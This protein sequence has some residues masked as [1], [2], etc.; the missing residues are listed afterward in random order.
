MLADQLALSPPMDRP[1]VA[2]TRPTATGHLRRRARQGV[3]LDHPYLFGATS[4]LTAPR[5]GNGV[6]D[7]A[8]ADRDVHGSNIVSGG[9][10]GGGNVSDTE[11]TDSLRGIIAAGRA[12]DRRSAG[13]EARIRVGKVWTPIAPA[14]PRSS[15][16]HPLAI[17]AGARILTSHSTS[18][19][20]QR[21]R[22]P[23]R[24]R[25]PGAT[26]AP[27]REQRPDLYLSPSYPASSSDPAVIASP[28]PPRAQPD[29]L[30]K[31]R[32]RRLTRRSGGGDPSTA[33]A[34]RSSTAPERRWPALCRC[35]LALL[36]AARPYIPQSDRRGA[37]RQARVERTRGPA[38]L[39]RAPRRSRC[40]PPAGHRW[41]RPR[42]PAPRWPAPRRAAR[43][44][45]RPSAGRVAAVATLRGGQPPSTVAVWL[46][47]STASACEAGGDRAAS[48]PS[49]SGAKDPPLDGRATTPPASESRR[50]AQLPAPR[51]ADG[52]ARDVSQIAIARLRTPRSCHGRRQWSRACESDNGSMSGW[53]SRGR[54][55]A[56]VHEGYYE[57]SSRRRQPG[58]TRSPGRRLS[59]LG[60]D[61]LAA[62]VGRRDTI[63]VPQV[64]TS[65]AR[66]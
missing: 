2:W 22:L 32:A 57:S 12:R 31:P 16:A 41:R 59:L 45:L 40:T 4:V 38:R 37:L 9:G 29:G 23:V 54:N 55:D 44:R 48:C 47:C 19:R 36:R 26:I 61:Q 49:E 21:P 52:A 66:R 20:R 62:A 50:D 35:P 15:R 24:P 1:W 65:T 17:D 64:I 6:D 56:Y 39:G 42:S 13:S 63:F 30:A 8:T 58:R 33:E 28:P 27:P 34:S 43:L 53:R 10:G 11:A 14:T 3:Q 7:D 25:A 18:T 51:R 5:P 46:V 60:P